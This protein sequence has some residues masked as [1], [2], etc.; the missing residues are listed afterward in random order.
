[1]NNESPTPL[2]AIRAHCLRCSGGRAKE[3]QCCE[4]KDCMLYRFRFG[5]LPKSAKRSAKVVNG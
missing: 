5:K 3:V 2:K 4:I 1:M